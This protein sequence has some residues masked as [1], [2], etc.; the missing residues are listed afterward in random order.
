[1]GRRRMSPQDSFWL[2]LDRPNTLLVITSLVWTA[3]PV[4]PDRFRQVVQ[5]RVIDRYPVFSQRPVLSGGLIRSGYWEDVP[6]FDLE[7]HIVVRDMP[8]PGDR[9]A[10]ERFVAEQRSVPLDRSRP[11]WKTYVL[12]GYQG[13]SAIVQ[14]YHHAMADG[15]RLTQVMLSLL[16]PTDEPVELSAR[17]GGRTPV[18][19][20]RGLVRPVASALN[21][22]ASVLKIGLW[23]NPHSALDGEPGLEK[24]A[25]WTDPLP[26]DAI[27]QIARATGTSVN[28][29]CTTLVAGAMA[30]YLDARAGRPRLAAGDEDVAWMI[31][32][33][34]EPPDREPPAELGNHFALVLAVLPHG[35]AVFPERLAEIHRR[36][37]R[38]RDSWEPVFTFGLTRGIAVSPSAVGTAAIW[39]LAAK[40]VGVLT[41]VPG[42]REPV[43][44]AGARV[45]GAVAWAPTSNKQALTV[46]IFSYAGGVTFGFGTDRTIVPDADRLVQGLYAEFADARATVLG[47]PEAGV[48]SAAND[49]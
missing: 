29:V 8:A 30:R 48:S 40:G 10:L 31:P 19:A 14:R 2:E 20:R 28:D 9:A 39:F 27:K 25:A 5:E 12:Q 35:P 18:P 15:V 1:M 23:G 47:R 4:D 16:D 36:I 11:L 26:L 32:L 42:P 43:S 46:C 17:V 38:I 13:G 37:G 34:L 3:E 49:G 33:N 7:D 21:T 22:A 44:F 41:N 6:D 24:T 45:A